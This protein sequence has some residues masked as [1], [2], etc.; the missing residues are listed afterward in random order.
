MLN[1]SACWAAPAALALLAAC[2]SKPDPHG[3]AMFYGREPMV[4]RI[5]GDTTPL[6]PIATRCSNCHEKDNVSPLTG[7]S[8]QSYAPRLSHAWLTG[9]RVR[10]GG[11]ASRY[12]LDAFC[13]LLRDGIDPA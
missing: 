13:G 7:K 4:G 12:D 1:R 3:E 11:P 8:G 10:R 6:P 5:T 2:G 9:A